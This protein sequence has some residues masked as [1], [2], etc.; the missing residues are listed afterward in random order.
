LDK[1]KIAWQTGE[2]GKIDIG[3]GGTIGMYLSRYG[4]NCV[5]A[6]PAVFGMHSPCEISSKIDV[7]TSYLFYR[8]F[9]QE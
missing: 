2:L 6:G 5:D 1:N 3:G 8:A 9:L 4:M 7:Y